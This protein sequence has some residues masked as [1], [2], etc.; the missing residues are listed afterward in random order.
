MHEKITESCPNFQPSEIPQPASIQKQLDQIKIHNLKKNN[1]I[2]IEDS[3][4]L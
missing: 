3:K 1:S 4:L 2:I